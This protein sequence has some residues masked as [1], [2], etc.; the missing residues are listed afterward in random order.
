M[1]KVLTALKTGASKIEIR[2]GRH[3]RS[4]SPSGNSDRARNEVPDPT[5]RGQ[6]PPQ[7]PLPPLPGGHFPDPFWFCCWP[8]FSSRFWFWNTLRWPLPLSA[9]LGACLETCGAETA[10]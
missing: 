6:L 1:E 5:A 3:R 10:G 9:I 7:E 2:S 8:R 4:G